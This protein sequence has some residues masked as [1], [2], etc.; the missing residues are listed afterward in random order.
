MSYCV[1]DALV[2]CCCRNYIEGKQVWRRWAMK[3]V[4]GRK[5]NPSCRLNTST[6]HQMRIRNVKDE[7]DSFYI[8]HIATR[9]QKRGLT[10]YNP[11][12]PF[13]SD[14]LIKKP[15]DAPNW[16]VN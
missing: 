2:C 11:D 3:T 6:C 9:G 8:A 10:S 14:S 1:I 16:A 12:D 15:E 4:S 13:G 5:W 7:M